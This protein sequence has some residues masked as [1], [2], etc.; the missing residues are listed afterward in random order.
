[1]SMKKEYIERGAAIAEIQSIPSGTIHTDYATFILGRVPCSDV[2]LIPDCKINDKV[3]VKTGNGSGK[4]VVSVD[5][6]YIDESGSYIGHF[7]FDGS[8][9]RWKEFEKC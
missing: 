4:S 3:L 9:M 2:I 5:C 7:D 8:L 6:F 1:M